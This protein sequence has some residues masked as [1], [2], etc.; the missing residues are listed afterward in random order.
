MTVLL[1]LALALLLLGAGRMAIGLL[2]GEEFLPSFI[3]LVIL[4]PGVL[5]VACASVFESYFAGINRRQY[6]SYS[7]GCAFALGVTLVI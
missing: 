5:A 3:P 1:S 7:A 6:Q 2:F 4:L